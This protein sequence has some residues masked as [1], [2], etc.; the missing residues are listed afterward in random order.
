MSV[1]RF[2]RADDAD[3]WEVALRN[4]GRAEGAGS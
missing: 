2:G 1:E 3:V 4:Y